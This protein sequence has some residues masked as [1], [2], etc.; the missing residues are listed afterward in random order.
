MNARSDEVVRLSRLRRRIAERLV[1]ARRTAPHVWG[2]V[3]ADYE[4][5][6][7][8]RRAH[9]A[10]F[11][12]RTGESLT[13]LP[14]VAA[15]VAGAL[16]DHPTVNSSLSADGTTMT[17]HGEI[18]LG[19]AVDL[20]GEGLLVVTVRGADA[21]RVPQLAEQIGDLARRARDNRLGRDDVVGST[22]TIT[23]PGAFGSLL[24]APIINLPNVAILSSDAVTKRCVV[25]TGADGGRGDGG[26]CDD[27]A[28]MAEVGGGAGESVTGGGGDVVGIRRVGALGLS[29]DHRAFDGSTAMAFLATVRQGI[30]QRDWGREF[31]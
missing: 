16:A 9:R 29:W 1:R 22:F 19:I 12:E 27:G 31:S 28:D 4:A 24:S 30:E 3:E 14:F 25:V 6:D 2:A 8:V 7:A 21:L 15:A 18:N 23:N 20:S 11:A 17:L 26:V 13:Y 5:V 10:A